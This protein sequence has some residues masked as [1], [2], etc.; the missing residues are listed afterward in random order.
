MSEFKSLLKKTFKIFKMLLTKGT[1]IPESFTY[2]LG[3][4]FPEVQVH[5]AT[6]NISVR[7]QDL[8]KSKR[9]RE[10]VAAVRKTVDQVLR[11]RENKKKEDL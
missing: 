7:P 10:Q 5:V 1:T 9:V 4:D 3:E 11:E 8:Y 6:G 2:K